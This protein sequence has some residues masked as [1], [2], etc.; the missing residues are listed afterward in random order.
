M[1]LNLSLSADICESLRQAAG[2]RGVSRYLERLVSDSWR[3]WQEALKLLRGGGWTDPE[4]LSSCMLLA[5]IWLQGAYGPH[6]VHAKLADAS[7]IGRRMALARKKNID[8]DHWE[9]RISALVNDPDRA[10]AVWLISREYW[11]DNLEMKKQIGDSEK[12]RSAKR[13]G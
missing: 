11:R 10:N 3:E 4:I 5:G 1:A 6:Q 9:V 12:K 2:D 7:A 8:V 13:A